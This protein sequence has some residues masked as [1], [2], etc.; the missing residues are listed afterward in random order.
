MTEN[1]KH[2][3]ILTYFGSPDYNHPKRAFQKFNMNKEYLEQ[4]SIIELEE[5]A[6]HAYEKSR[7]YFPIRDVVR[8]ISDILFVR[9]LK[10]D[11]TFEWSEENK[12]KFLK[13][14]NAITNSF[15]NAYNEALTVAKEL[16]DKESNNDPFIKDFEVEIQVSPYIY[17]EDDI[18]G[19]IYAFV[20]V[21]CQPFNGHI[22]ISDSINCDKNIDAKIDVIVRISRDI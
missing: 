11:E 13:V 19:Y 17:M 8:I 5:I 14:N 1:E 16:F 21:L 3:I 18:D 22:L 7:N 6:V 15:R 9:K 10:L 20:N 2:E 12:L 4:Y